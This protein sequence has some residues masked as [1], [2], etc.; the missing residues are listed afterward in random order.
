MGYRIGIDVG[1]TNTDSVLLD[2]SLN[3]LYKV[4]VKTHKNV[5][6]GID[7]SLTKLLE[8]S[9]VNP[10]Q[11]SHVMLGTTHCTN[12]IVERKN[13]NKI[14][15]IRIGAP[16]S[17]T[18]PPLSG[19]PNDMIEKIS[20]KAYIVSGGYEYDGRE[21]ASIDEAEI[22]SICNEVRGKV[23][24]IAIVGIFSP[25]NKEQEEKVASILKE[26]L[27]E[28]IH[29]S[30]SNEIGSVGLLERENATILN[31]A[32]KDTIREV[33][34]TFRQDLES[35]GINA[36]I[37]FC[38][39]DGTLMSSEFALQYP[40]LTIASGPTNSIRGAAHLTGLD[41]A[42]VID[43]GGTTTDIGV[44]VN[45]FP[46]E[47]SLA[48]EIGGVR[49]NFR[50]PDLLS[51]GLG[52]GTIIRENG[53]DISVGPDSVGYELTERGLI[54]G[55]ETF[56]A[57][58]VAIACGKHVID[59]AQVDRVDVKLAERAD[60]AMMKLV[61]DA[62]DRMKTSKELIPVIVVGGGSILISSD[63]KGVS[64][65]HRPNNYDAANAIGAAL[66]EVSGETDK[67]YALDNMTYEEVI[68]DAKNHAF[69]QAVQAGADPDTI[70]VVHMEDIPLAYLPGNSIH[71]KVKVAGSLL[72]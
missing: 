14:A 7:A 15:I 57:T 43:V 67:I 5:S 25:V 21:I 56:T 60:E 42:L 30:L 2:E 24:S 35:K 32:L 54:F 4:K 63:L 51:F 33:T 8:E 13:L 69:N 47:S 64:Q 72:K 12:A 11:I 61:E 62:I 18:I 46:R 44:L 48:V 58:D 50:M 1:G 16:A 52:G 27:G 37:Y 6:E 26:E 70:K 65:V 49:T 28:D 9:N 17:T 41:N 20:D 71:V 23:Q 38:Q 29:L 68:E 31:A 19:W 34:K 22:R 53:E 66:G 59:G 45:G 40:I 36:K 39:N 3:V 55:G 10:A